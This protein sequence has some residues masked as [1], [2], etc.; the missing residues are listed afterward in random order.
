MCLLAFLPHILDSQAKGR[1]A[2]LATLQ[3]VAKAFAKRPWGFAWV[4][5]C[6]QP[7]AP[8]PRGRR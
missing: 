7:G 5:G 3:E 6:T 4:R 2:Y 8:A 1:L